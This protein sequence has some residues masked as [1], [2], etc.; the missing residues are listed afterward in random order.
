MKN[1]LIAISLCALVLSASA[2]LQTDNALPNLTQSDFTVVERNSDGTIKSVRYAMTDNDIPATAE[3]FFQTTLKKRDADDFML[4]RSDDTD[5]GM[6]FERYQQYYQGVR[7]EDGHYNFRFKNGRMKVVKGHYVNV[8]GINTKPSLTKDEIINIYASYF[9]IKNSGIIEPYVDLIIKEIPNALNKESLAA[10][11]YKV[12]LHTNLKE[13]RYVG[14]INAHTGELLYKEDAIVNYSTNGQFYTYYNSS[15]NPKSGITDYSNGSY[16]LKD[17][18]HGNEI[19]TY[20]VLSNGQIGD[21]SDNNNIWTQNEMSPYNIALDV[22]WTMQQIYKWMYNAWGYSSYDGQNHNITS[23][24]DNSSY[25]GNDASFNNYS[26]RF[27]FGTSPGNTIFGPFGSVDIIG[28][29]YGHAIVF[30]KTGINN[31][32]FA[33]NAIHEGL[34]DIWGIIFEK[35]ITPSANYWKT[36]EQIMINGESCVRNFQ[37]PNDVIAH[38]QI[39]S[40]YG[41]GAFNSSDPHIVGGL[42]PRWFYLLVNGG[43]GTNGLNNSYQLLPVGFDLAER[44]VKETTLVPYYLQDCSTFQHVASEFVEAA[45]D[46]NDDFLAEQVKNSLYAVGLYPEPQHIYMQSYSP[47]SATYY[48]YGNQNCS[49]NWYFTSSYGALP[50]LVP[51][52]GNHTCTVNTSSSFGGYLNAT[53]SCGGCSAT[54]SRYIT[55]IASPSS[56]GDDAMRVIPLDGTHYQ[57]TVGDGYESGSIKVY[58]ALSLRTKTTERQF[59][60]SYVLDTSSLERG[61]YIVEVTI[62]SKTYSSKIFIK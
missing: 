55:G 47:G 2:Q 39:A 57:I 18:S 34:A 28:H 30:N 52:Y 26:N 27:V 32:S 46:M 29:E 3:E 17:T 35:H 38:T 43:S 14:Y 1:I 11:T 22:H 45:E 44:L 8:T 4:D 6:H 42:L 13:V 10:L 19:R 5:Y 31:S 20:K 21:I 40:T 9:G 15:T 59:V 37:N 48:V 51:N 50:T 16:I 62:G 25:Y 24:I 23:M 33:Q 54:Y 53:I 58:D 61:L 49:V 56:A 36:G 7:V 12:F 60:D 41:C